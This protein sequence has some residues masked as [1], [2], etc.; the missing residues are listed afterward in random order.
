MKDHKFG[1]VLKMK[2]NILGLGCLE[3]LLGK[4]SKAINR[5]GREKN[6]ITD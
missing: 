5:M 1:F 6:V 2:S 3:N 4:N